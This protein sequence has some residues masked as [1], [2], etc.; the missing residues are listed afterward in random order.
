[1]V[2]IGGVCVGGWLV[3]V[4]WVGGLVV[5]V[6]WVGGWCIGDGGFDCCVWFFVVLGYFV[7]V[8]GVGF[9]VDVCL[10]LLVVVL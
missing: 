10:W 3:G 2:W 5:V 7:V 9:V 6:W 8:D 1:M 4:V